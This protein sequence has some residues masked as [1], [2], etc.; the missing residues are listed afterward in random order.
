[1]LNA[2]TLWTDWH[3][4]VIYSNYACKISCRQQHSWAVC[5]LFNIYR[6]PAMIKQHL[7][8][9]PCS[10]RHVNSSV[11]MDFAVKILVSYWP[12]DYLCESANHA[13]GPQ[14]HQFTPLVTQLILLYVIASNCPSNSSRPSEKHGPSVAGGGKMDDEVWMNQD[15][16]GFTTGKGT[17][18]THKF[19]AWL[20]KSKHSKRISCPAFVGLQVHDKYSSTEM[21]IF[22]WHQ[23]QFS[24]YLNG[25]QL[26][27]AFREDWETC[28]SS[29]LATCLSRM[30]LR[31]S[32][33]DETV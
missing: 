7:Q 32:L 30:S 10:S 29:C 19:I 22:Y 26:L 11:L 18:T 25:E 6:A 20:W 27:N 24:C 23:A 21:F 4:F 2:Y 1:M 28:V 17:Q 14:G 9:N 12:A 3:E 31:T 13:A 5:L 15:E 33:M 16:F 8:Q